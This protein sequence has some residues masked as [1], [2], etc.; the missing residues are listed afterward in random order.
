[1]IGEF[2]TANAREARTCKKCHA[3]F[4]LDQFPEYLD[5]GT[6]RRRHTCRACMRAY[7]A[8]WKERKRD[9]N[10]QERAVVLRSMVGRMVGQGMQYV[11]I[12]SAAG[13]CDRTVSRILT[14]SAGRTRFHQ[15]T[16]ARIVD[17]FLEVKGRAA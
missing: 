1:M 14:G 11:D 4:T 15:S 3:A 7:H 12:A 13:V 8:A 16:E 10:Y 9:V 17:V 2:G 5:R 6:V